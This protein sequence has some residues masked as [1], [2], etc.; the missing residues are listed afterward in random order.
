MDFSSSSDALAIANFSDP[1]AVLPSPD[2]ADSASEF[3]TATSLQRGS[4]ASQSPIRGAVEVVSRPSAKRSSP[5]PA[6]AELKPGALSNDGR[7]L[8]YASPLDSLVTHDRN[9]VSDIFLYDRQTD[10]TKKITRSAGTGASF[11]LLGNQATISGN[12]RYVV[13]DA[14]ATDLLPNPSSALYSYDIQ[15][16]A[17]SNIPYPSSTPGSDSIFSISTS[18]DGRYVV[19][20]GSFGNDYTPRSYLWDR[21]TNSTTLFGSDSPN[22]STPSSRVFN[23]VLSADGNF[24]SYSLSSDRGD[25]NIYVWDRRSGETTLISKTP[26]G[27]IS[28]GSNSR[29]LVISGDGRFVAFVS[30]G[31]P[32]VPDDQNGTE[33]VYL[34]DRQTG[35]TSLVDRTVLGTGSPRNGAT[36]PVL[37]RNGNYLAFSS[38]ANDIVPYDFNQY[39]DPEPLVDL[40]ATDVFGVRLA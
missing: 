9:A 21:Q 23:P 24:V 12:G 36:S 22:A 4:S 10:S 37:S 13:F 35:I 2:F 32:L 15:T 31:A 27:N 26:A 11:S 16:G 34:W 7:Y 3:D 39:T 38:N 25:S 18:Q 28:P 29:D 5:P 14:F 8:V 30:G 6:L 17:L 1:N 40:N 20:R 33:D 19:F